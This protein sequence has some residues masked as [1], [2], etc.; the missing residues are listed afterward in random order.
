MSR[1]PKPL[2]SGDRIVLRS[3]GSDDRDAFLLRVAESAEF[4]APWAYPPADADA[5][6]EYLARTRA[7]NYESYWACRKEDGAHVGVVNVS[8]IVRGNFQ[9]AY[10]GYYVFARFAGRGY[11]TEAL[12]LAVGHAFTE[13][14]LH[15]LEANI[16]PRNE[17]SIALARRCGFHKEGFSPRYLKVGGAW[18]DHERWA[19]TREDWAKTRESGG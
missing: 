1:D 8:E 11:M 7:G 13:L 10:L 16:Q 12:K 14:G 15:R 4:I 2:P 3:P 19:L 5:F 18:Q 17:P 9:S 6:R